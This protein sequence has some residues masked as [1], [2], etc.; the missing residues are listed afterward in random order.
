MMYVNKIG[1]KRIISN[2]DNKTVPDIPSLLYR[3]MKLMKLNF[4]ITLGEYISFHAYNQHYVQENYNHGELNILCKNFFCT[5][6][7]LAQESLM[8]P[9]RH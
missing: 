3:K 8:I 7:Y 4:I 1:L 5:L 6:W 2:E 9:Q